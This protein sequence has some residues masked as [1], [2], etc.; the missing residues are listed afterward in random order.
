[1]ESTNIKSEL[2]LLNEIIFQAY[3]LGT[4]SR[5]DAN[6]NE[7]VLDN[8]MYEYLKSKGYDS[9]YR[10]EKVGVE[11]KE[12][13]A[14]SGLPKDKTHVI[15]WA[16]I[17]KFSPM[18]D[19]IEDEVKNSKPKTMK[20]YDISE[21][22][23]CI[24]NIIEEAICHGGDSGDKEGAYYSNI[25]GIT[26]AIRKYLVLKNLVGKYMI[27]IKEDK[28]TACFY[29]FDEMVQIVKAP[30]K[31]TGLN[32]TTAMTAMKNGKKVRR[33]SWTSG[34]YV[35]FVSD[36]TYKNFKGETTHVHNT[37]N[38]S[39]TMKVDRFNNI[40]LFWRANGYD[41]LAEDWEILI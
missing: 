11:K 7:N 8:L 22:I 10:V 26:E 12:Y 38:N 15:P 2:S 39:T 27:G 4:G 13:G 29:E 31:P 3:N 6:V 35:E 36:V 18:G 37:T 28:S 32:F 19:T 30:E 25:E 21:E 9:D 23:D 33:S 41:I 14:D 1:M 24:N 20:V 17:F 5:L 16:S 40:T 34:D